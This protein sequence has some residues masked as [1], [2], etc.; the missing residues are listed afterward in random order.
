MFLAISVTGFRCR[1]RLK[2]NFD[3]VE[4]VTRHDGPDPADASGHE[5]F[6]H[7]ERHPCGFKEIKSRLVDL[8]SR[9]G[10]N[11][12]GSFL[13][14]CFTLKLISFPNFFLMFLSFNLL[15]FRIF[16]FENKKLLTVFVT[17]NQFVLQ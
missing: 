10:L 2:S 7:L 3:C 9:F 16:Q 13:S 4:G 5:V 11:S 1:H 17:V 6:H 14:F 8:V 12:K 15:D